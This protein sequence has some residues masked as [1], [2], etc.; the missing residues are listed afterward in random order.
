MSEHVDF[1]I[2]FILKH[3][4]APVAGA[5]SHDVFAVNFLHVTLKSR[6]RTQNFKATL[7]LKVFEDLSHV[8]MHSFNVDFKFLRLTKFTAAKV[9]QRSAPLGIFRTSVRSMHFQIIKT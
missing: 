7:A 2:G 9:A 6:S 3:F 4:P 1:Q 8:G 5:S